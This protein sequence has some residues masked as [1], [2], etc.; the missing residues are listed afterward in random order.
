MCGIE[1]ALEEDNAPM[2]ES[3]V[4]MDLMLHAYMFMQSGIPVIYSGDEIGQLNDYTYKD[5]PDKAADSRYIHRGA[6]RWED[7]KKRS[8]P[9]TVQ[10]KI[11]DQLRFLEKLRSE[12]KVF[13]SQADVWTL[14]T[15]QKEVLAIGRYYDGDKLIGVF[16]FSEHDRTAWINETDGMYEDMITGQKMEAKGVDIPAYGYYYLKKI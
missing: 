13:V 9:G 14:E 6:F 2:L 7:A 15:W 8:V 5:N 10:Q 16:N 4:Q 1:R 3:S 11:F 12:E